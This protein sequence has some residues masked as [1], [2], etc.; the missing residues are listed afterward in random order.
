MT[1]EE[2]IATLEAR[3]DALELAASPEG[4]QSAMEASMEQGFASTGLAAP[5]TGK[6]VSPVIGAAFD[7]PDY[8]SAGGKLANYSNTLDAKAVLSN[9][10][11]KQLNGGW[12][13]S[14][15]KFLGLNALECGISVKSEGTHII[16]I[17]HNGEI[18]DGVQIEAKVRDWKECLNAG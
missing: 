16:Y 18:L 17:M 7:I 9:P 10:A 8:R 2:R 14:I 1:I 13:S 6:I 15:D 3:V 4:V 5:V 12:Y 11:I